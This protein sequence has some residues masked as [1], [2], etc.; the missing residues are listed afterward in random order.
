MLT[1]ILRYNHLAFNDIYNLLYRY[2]KKVLNLGD[3]SIKLRYLLE[4]VIF[5]EN[6]KI[7]LIS[8]R[9]LYSSQGRGFS[10]PIWHI[11]CMKMLAK[12][13][14]GFI[15]IYDIFSNI[16]LPRIIRINGVH[17]LYNLFNNISEINR[18]SYNI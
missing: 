3:L 9:I 8:C 2:Y 7:L 5:I 15:R 4:K 1:L 10:T 13:Y 11:I 12:N 18:I 6:K 14:K 17:Y 16:F